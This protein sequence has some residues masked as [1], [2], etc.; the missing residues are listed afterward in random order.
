MVPSFST[1]L[2]SDLPPARCAPCAQAQPLSARFD[3]LRHVQLRCAAGELLWFAFT[4]PQAAAAD[5]QQ[6]LLL[7]GCWEAVGAAQGVGVCGA[8]PRA[9]VA[10]A[11]GVS[12]T[13][14]Y[15][16]AVLLG[17]T[18][19]T[20]TSGT[21]S[22]ACGRVSYALGLGG[23]SV[24]IDTACSSALVGVHLALTSFLPGAAA[25]ALA[26]GVNL[27]L[28]AETTAVLSKAGMLAPDGRCK[29]LDV[30][31]DGYARAE[32]CVVHLLE[33]MES[34]LGTSETAAPG[35][36][37]A[38]VILG[39]CVNQD[40][41]SSSLTAPNGPAQQEAVRSA[42]R[43]A[44]GDAGAAPAVLEMHGTGT[45]L[46]DPIEVGAA[47]AVLQVRLPVPRRRPCARCLGCCA[48]RTDCTGTRRAARGGAT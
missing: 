33:R 11:V 30:A 31:A 45:A 39:S 29:T 27:T 40:G 38:A 42:L 47:L 36:R 12:Y 10:V 16:N 2:S 25:A 13:E 23:P 20:A 19:Y 22:V 28:R 48:C 1:T 26:A 21:L 6:R 43:A 14:Y 15:H 34:L 44:G 9:S 24:S 8:G 7:E 5:P 37:P 17:T 35:R 3:P 18:A 32:A 46:G 4:F 41:R